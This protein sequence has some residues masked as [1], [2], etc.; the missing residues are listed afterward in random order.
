MQDKIIE[1]Y[2]MNYI[3]NSLTYDYLLPQVTNLYNSNSNNNNSL[4]Y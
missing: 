3:L 2:L 1:K 4:L